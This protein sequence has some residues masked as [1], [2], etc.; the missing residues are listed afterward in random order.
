MMVPWIVQLGRP[1][2]VGTTIAQAKKKHHDHESRT[3]PQPLCADC[4]TIIYFSNVTV[5]RKERKFFSSP[6]KCMI[7]FEQSTL[8][9]TSF[10]YVIMYLLPS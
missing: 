4:I 2:W 8:V 10:P 6:N 3:T 9:L 5:F 1:E 7:W